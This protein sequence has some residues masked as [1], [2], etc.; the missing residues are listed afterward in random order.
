MTIMLIMSI[1]PQ[2]SHGRS[3]LF[4]PIALDG[5]S[6]LVQWF[7]QPG[8]CCNDYN[9]TEQTTWRSL[10]RSFLSPRTQFHRCLLEHKESISWLKKWNEMD[11]SLTSHI[12]PYGS[13]RD[14]LRWMTLMM[15]Q[16]GIRTHN[17]SL[18][19][20]FIYIL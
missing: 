16:P 5:R 14:I 17:L 3:T 9:C 7:P 11:I 2:R 1:L 15:G 4:Q 13:Y 6:H 18:Q 20:T 12:N 19:W 8:D 10:E